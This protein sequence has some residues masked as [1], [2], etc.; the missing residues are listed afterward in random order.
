MARPPKRTPTILVIDDDPSILE[1]ETIVL[2]DHGFNVIPSNSAK[3]ALAIVADSGPI[4]LVLCDLVLVGEMDGWSF[5]E[6]SREIR[7]KIK[8]VFTS[9][10]VAAPAIANLESTGT[11]VLRKPWRPDELIVF[12]RRALAS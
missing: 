12:I 8:I 10:Y 3:E 11:H 2:A 5:A 1:I 9:G 6:R 4:D 7:P